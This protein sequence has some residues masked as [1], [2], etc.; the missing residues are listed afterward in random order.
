M[1]LLQ[2]VHNGE[3]A[4][5]GKGGESENGHT[6]RD[7]LR[8]FRKLAD[9]LAPGPRFQRVNHRGEGHARYYNQ[10]VGQGEREDVP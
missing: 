4:I 7:V 5:G 3:E 1:K 2:R 9:Q 8:S 6:N 10:Q